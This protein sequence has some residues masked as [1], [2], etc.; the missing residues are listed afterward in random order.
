M[1][2]VSVIALNATMVIWEFIWWYTPYREETN[3]DEAPLKNIVKTK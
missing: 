2:Q 1:F 3:I